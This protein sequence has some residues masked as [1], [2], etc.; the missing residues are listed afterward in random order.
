MYWWG[1]VS[2]RY[3]INF[4]LHVS[5]GGRQPLL[6]NSVDCPLIVATMDSAYVCV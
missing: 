6:F 5:F 3:D 4:D 1:G 2:V